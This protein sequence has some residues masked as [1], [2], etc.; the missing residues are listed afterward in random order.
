[1]DDPSKKQPW[2][3]SLVAVDPARSSAF[4][5]F[6]G[7]RLYDGSMGATKKGAPFDGAQVHEVEP[8]FDLLDDGAR[9]LR[10]QSS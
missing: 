3:Q 5:G 1:M 8:L 7:R 6:S 9:G 10:R 2:L 4:C